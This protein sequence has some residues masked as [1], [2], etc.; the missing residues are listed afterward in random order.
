MSKITWK[1]VM[2]VLLA[3]M[4]AAAF[5]G[6]AKSDGEE[7]TT[8]GAEV[9]LQTQATTAPV[10]TTEAT[11]E[12]PTTQV[13]TTETTTAAPKD[14]ESIQGI[15]DTLESKRFYMAGTMNLNGGQ[16]VDA[17][18]TCDGD[19]Y[20]LEMVS[21][22]LKMSIIYLD[23]TPYLANNGT[24]SYVVIDDAAMANMDQVMTS[25]SAFGVSFNSQDISEMKSMMANFDQNMDY[26][27]YIND[28]EYSEYTATV[29]GQEY[30]CSTYKTD[31]GTIRIYTQDGTLKIID[32]FDADG[33]RQMNFVVS[34]FIPEVLSPISLNGY[35]KAASI[36]NLFTAA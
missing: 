30:L 3:V 21:A 28:G 14:G 32:V 26:S 36:L 6:C 7:P 4:M 1:K 13:H 35:T 29:D 2:S 5:A 19:N 23:G 20:R 22:Q 34:A 17:K 8:D 16:T 18:A 33:L 15:I 31:Y 11:T 27:Q 9:M 10:T 24:N 12:A 25:L